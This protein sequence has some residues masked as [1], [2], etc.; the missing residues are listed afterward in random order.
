[1]A[2]ISIPKEAPELYTLIHTLTPSE[3]RSYRRY[4]GQ[5]SRKGKNNYLTLFDLLEGMDAWSSEGL[6]KK[7]QRHRFTSHYPPTQLKLQK[8]LLK[9]L[10]QSSSDPDQSLKD[11]INEIRILIRRGLYKT[12]KKQH[13]KAVAEAKSREKYLILLELADL[14]RNLFS[15]TVKKE[16][17]SALDETATRD[18]G[19]LHCLEE[20]I[21]LNQLT[22]QAYG[23]AKIKYSPGEA[24]TDPQVQA[25]EASLKDIKADHLLSDTARLSYFNLQ[26][27]TELRKGEHEAAFHHYDALMQLWQKKSDLGAE[28]ITHYLPGLTNF[29]NACLFQGKF[30]VFENTLAEMK[31]LP[32]LNPFDRIRLEENLLYLEL[33]FNLNTTRFE[34]GISMGPRIET[35][36]QTYPNLVP[37][38]KVIIYYYNL[39][40]LHFLKG[41]FS[42]ALK[43]TNRIIN[44]TRQEFRKDIR[45][46]LRVLRLVMHLE[47]GDWDLMEYLLR[48]TKR[49]FNDQTLPMRIDKRMLKLISD[50]LKTGDEKMLKIACAG[51]RK[52]LDADLATRKTHPPVGFTEV[53][54][55]LESKETGRSLP[56]IFRE[57]VG[58]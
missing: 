19:W 28:L 29:L 47:K 24:T 22:I 51:M 49:F 21:R 8:N 12:A 36:L 41:D 15:R 11:S 33:I 13:K 25:L 3:K 45:N 18:K 55:W 9:F 14:E 26:G 58:L 30:Q 54:C 52:A 38:S 46:I 53:Y 57:K 5:H 1:M 34:E 4:A 43:W 2:Q 10:R 16:L 32:L 17:I 37:P 7:L 39:T 42:G 31:A 35:Y 40:S 56:E 48:A 23:L 50:H 27:L 20:Q 44:E 6:I